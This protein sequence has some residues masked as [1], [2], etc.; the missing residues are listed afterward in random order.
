MGIRQGTRAPLRGGERRR[1]VARHV[2]HL[3]YVTAD[4]GC[5]AVRVRALVPR[6]V[7]QDRDA[8]VGSTGC[9][10][11]KL[12]RTKNAYVTLSDRVGTC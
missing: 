3:Q 4:V 7:W 5:M 1:V 10:L 12:G 6:R 2:R 9:I 8:R 11:Q